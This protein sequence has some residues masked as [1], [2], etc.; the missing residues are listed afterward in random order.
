MLRG[1]RTAS[2]NW[3]GRTVM[4]VVMGLLAASFAIWGINDIFRGFGRSTLAKIG[5]TEIPVEQ[6]RRA[7]EDRMQQLSRQFGKPIPPE[8]AKAFGVDR[9]VLIGLINDA[10][11]D[12]LARQMRL[13]VPDDVIVRQITEQP[14]FRGPTGQFDRGRFEQF[15][16]GVG[17][18][19]QRLVAEQ[20]HILL[21]RQ[22]VDSINGQ[23]PVPKA[24]LEAVNQ[25]QNE[26]RAIAYVALGPAQAG[27]IPA[28]TPEQLT[29]Y[30]EERKILF[31]A[32]EYR[33]IEVI[34]VTPEELGRWMDISDADIKTEFDEHHS[35]YVT[36]ERRHVE[37]IVFPNMQDAEAAEAR[38]KGGLSFTALA[39][40]RGLKDTD[41]NLGTVTKSELI[42]PAVANA[43]FALKDGEV[44]APVQGR[45]GTVIVTANKIE[46]EQVKSLADVTPQIRKEIAAE[47]AKAEVH[48]LH[49]KIED[50]RAGG[51]SLPQIA[52]KLKLT[53]VT[54][55][56]DRSGRDPSGKVAN[57][58][59]AGQVIP[60][61]FNSDVGADNDPV[62]ADGGYV[63]YNVAAITPSRD[64]TLDEV[65]DQV[66]ARWRDDEI[67]SR[68]KAKAADLL[69]KLKAG[70]P[71]E[72]VA[73]GAGVKV[74]TADK[75]TR[76]KPEAG[77]SAR[78]VTA[79]F[80]TAKDAYGSSEGDQPTDWVVFRVTDITAPKFEADAVE[81]KRLSDLIKK[82][83]SDELLEQ[84]LAWMQTDLGT[85][86][87]QSALAQALGNAPADAN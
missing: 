87:N 82:Q 14:F 43:A 17:M 22:I 77:L 56:V 5:G 70:T 24:W 42:D 44:S 47:R 71:L 61:A 6:F 72:E 8:Q 15:L 33:K 85:S 26:Q 31:R 12:Q 66:E 55:D 48:S 23:M 45:F 62:D 30:F 74:Q 16:R 3:L 39:A 50:E 57:F 4:A 86:F 67:A 79:V 68:L 75:L 25:F 20:R 13:G 78:A 36:P 35:R 19:E 80:R 83:E 60:A 51:A 65:K 10:G 54:Y 53:V 49:E 64:R 41:T 37:Q 59:H 76:G 63:W 34:A 7:Y 38:L 1:I 58:P 69:D 73:A 2:T 21:R 84:Y 40:E 27:D 28:P 9:A 52:E 29:K 32:P 46:P 81:I 18:S 11:L